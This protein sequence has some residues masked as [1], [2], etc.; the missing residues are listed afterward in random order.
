MVKHRR[1]E[2]IIYG[3]S[4]N[5]PFYRVAYRVDGKRHMKSFAIYGGEDGAKKWAEDKVRELAKGSRVAALTPSEANDALAALERLREFYQRSGRRL[6]LLASV[7]EYCEAAVKSNGRNLGEVMDAY[8]STVASVKRKDISEAMEQFIETRKA[9]TV[10]REEGKRPKLSPEHFY[11]TSIWLREF[12]A[13]F[14]GNAVS[15]LTKEHLNKYM[16]KHCKAAPKTRNERRGVVKMF[17]R[18]CGEQDYLAGN[19]R[20]F[21][22]SD[23]RSEDDSPETIDL[24]TADELRTV[25]ERASKRP[26]PPKEGQEPEADYRELLPVLALAGLAGMRLK[27]IMRLD[28]SDVFHKSGHIEVKAHKS[29]TR[30]RRLIQ[31]CPSLAGWLEPYRSRTGLVWSKS[32]DMFHIGFAALRESLEVPNRRNGL[33]H[34]FVSAHFAKYSDEGLTAAQAGNSPAMIHANYKGLMTKTEGEEWFAAA[35]EL[36]ANI[37]PLAAKTVTQEPQ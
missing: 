36:P 30:S 16:G 17:L 18:W 32:Y 28:W 24:Y 21:E 13:T 35:P 5:Y 33:R 31:I 27:E 22:A 29:K 25:L 19:H 2:A 9:K 8:L 26:E 37:I 7:S 12:A 23:M 15:D 11:N 3:K 10:P 4:E 6:S 14:P 34:A 1:A 20:L